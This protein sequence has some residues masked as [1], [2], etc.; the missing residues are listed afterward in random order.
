M[1]TWNSSPQHELATNPLSG[2]LG[3]DHPR[4][5]STRHPAPNSTPPWSPRRHALPHHPGHAKSQRPGS[6]TATHAIVGIQQTTATT[7][8][9]ASGQAQLIDTYEG[10][11]LAG[12]STVPIVGACRCRC[13]H[14]QQHAAARAR[15]RWQWGNAT[16]PPGRGRRHPDRQL[17]HRQGSQTRR[18]ARGHSRICSHRAVHHRAAPPPTTSGKPYGSPSQP[19]PGP[20]AAGRPLLLRSIKIAGLSGPD[21]RTPYTFQADHAGFDSLRP[22][23]GLSTELPV[24]YRQNCGGVLF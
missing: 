3:A 22:A 21:A 18:P 20:R 8:R 12:N 23:Q 16:P 6:Q 5:R 17:R 2:K 11:E 4:E 15:R 14:G 24:S 19:K 1:S 9:L 10:K 7:V 13:P